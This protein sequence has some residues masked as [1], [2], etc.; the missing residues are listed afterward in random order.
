MG[1]WVSRCVCACVCVPVSASV[2]A[3]PLSLHLLL[4]FCLSLLMQLF[5]EQAKACFAK[6]DPEGTDEVSAWEIK[7]SNHVSFQA[8]ALK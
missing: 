1:G 3:I 8:S 2:C 7:V 4:I 6:H 5:L